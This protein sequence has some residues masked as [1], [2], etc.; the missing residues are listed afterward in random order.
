MDNSQQLDP[1]MPVREKLKQL[2]E[3]LGQLKRQRVSQRPLSERELVFNWAEVAQ[4][5]GLSRMSLWR[6]RQELPPPPLPTFKSAIR[7][8]AQ[9]YGLPRKRGPRAIPGL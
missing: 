7:R 2:R 6:Y 3:M 1:K 8:W 5:L 9:A 4:V